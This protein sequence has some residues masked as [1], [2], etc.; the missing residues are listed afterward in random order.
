MPCP[1]ASWIQSNVV[2]VQKKW[3]ENG[4]AGKGKVTEGPITELIFD[5]VSNEEPT[6]SQLEF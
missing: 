1:G 6:T 4:D 5:L 3:N 2:S